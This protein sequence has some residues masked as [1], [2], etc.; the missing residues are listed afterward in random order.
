MAARQK[1]NLFLGLLLGTQ[2]VSPICA[3]PLKTAP[4]VSFAGGVL[5]IKTNRYEVQWQSGSMISARSLLPKA[6]ALTIVGTPMNVEQ[7]PNGLGSFHEQE[8][9]G[10]AQ[11]H[12]WG[13]ISAPF[14]AQHPPTVETKVRFEKLPDGARLTYTGL[15]GDAGATL[16]QELTVEERTGDLVIAQHG[17]SP[18]PGVFGVGFS[19]LN[20]RPDIEWA[21]PYFGG[22]R[23]KSDAHKGNVTSIAWPL[24]WNAGLIIGQMPQA[25]AFAVWAEDAAMRPK[26]LRHFNGDGVQAL[27][28]EACN[29]WPYHDKR[30][31]RAFNWRFNTFGGTKETA[32]MEA[33]Q[34]YKEWMVKAHKMV[35]RAR[36]S[37]RWV[38][39]I[40]LIW[41]SYVD[42]TTMKKMS[43]IIEPKRVL[44]MDWGWLKDFN[45]RIP[46]YKPQDENLASK[47]ALAHRY[48]FRTGIYTSMAL[49]DK[50]THPNLMQ[51]YGLEPYFNGLQVDKPANNADWLV[52]VH[53]GSPKWR[54]FYSEKMRDVKKQYGIDLLYQDVTGSGV[55]SAGLID[56]KSFSAG[57]VAVES[58][59]RTKVPEAALAGE[60]WTEVNAAHEDFGLT[61]FLAWGDE[62][63]KTWISKADQPHPLLSYLFSDYCIYWPHQVSVRDTKRFHQDQNINEV[64]GAIPTWDASPDD[65]VSEARVVLERAKLWA[66]GFRP[67]FPRQWKQGAV[68]Y[69]RDS[70]GRLVRYIRRG[71]SSYCYEETSRGDRLRYARI[72]GQNRTDIGSPVMIDG[73]VAYDKQSPIGLNPNNW[74]CLF[75]GAPPA[76]G[77]TIT[78]LPT[79]AYIN[80][81]R[82]SDQYVL[83]ELGGQ[84]NGTISWRTQQPLVSVLTGANRHD[85]KAHKATVNL[86]APVL[87]AFK[88][89]EAITE[90]AL[91]PL[92]KWPHRM[93]S[94]GQ[95]VGQAA[96]H[97]EVPRELELNG[98]KRNG[99]Q[100]IP[101]LGGVGSEHSIDG[102]VRLPND[103]KIALKTSLGRYGGSGD[104]VNFVVRVNGQEIW[105]RFSESK[106]GW[107]DVAI[108]LGAFAGQD[109]VLSLAVD[110]GPSGFNTSNDEAL[111]GEAKVD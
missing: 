107:E 1:I 10:R 13:A 54:Q 40:A 101:P 86:P 58:E 8:A 30:E 16:V 62:A 110:C 6:A 52:Y 90:G 22:Q 37:P 23:W 75:P 106:A 76:T 64:I 82:R 81:T 83:L 84:G 4:A 89:P 15:K 88:P 102:F 69:L 3:A 77:F 18:H 47:I 67:A 39:E 66:A 29:E 50:E 73:W 94:N 97:S 31:I 95:A 87:F 25:G 11:H 51:Q 57:V 38:D 103:P 71:G 9:A 96:V 32:W 63:H 43:E 27:E 61:T 104:G 41:P 55:G 108:P 36:R 109:V 35:P 42:E 33:A 91:L 68:S 5:S 20:L 72:T 12:P 44:M 48:G 60:F 24:F 45:R 93:V 70:K 7:M 17:I 49:V 105:R 85:L 28:F 59:I 26:Y 14:S 79:D 19:L 80:G 21:V 2:L 56:G 99:Y 53:P 74:Y 46:E 100:V 78:E 111:W 98:Q 92:G 65:R 34:R